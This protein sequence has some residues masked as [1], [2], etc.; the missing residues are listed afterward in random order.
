M[1]SG[2][3]A[4]K[5]CV[6]TYGRHSRAGQCIGAGCGVPEIVVDVGGT[7]FVVVH[8]LFCCRAK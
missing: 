8:V 4:T 5:V 7:V 1:L 6:T 2:V 3:H